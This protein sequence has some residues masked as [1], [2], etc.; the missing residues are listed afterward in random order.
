M[1]T[2]CSPARLWW[3]TI[4]PTAIPSAALRDVPPG[5]YY[6]QAVLHRYETFHRSDGHTVKLPM[7]RGEG[8]HWNI[9]PGNLYSTPQKITLEPSA[10]PIAIVLDQEI[11]PIPPPQDTKYIRHIKIQSALL[12]KFWGRPMY[13]SANVLVPEGFDAHTNVHFPLII[14]EDH[15]NADFTG[16]RTEPPDPNLKP[17]YSERFHI[18]GYNR[19]QQEE[20]YKFYQQWIAPGF[21]RVLIAD[22]NHANPYYDDSYAVNSA[23][24]GPLWRCHRDRTHSRDR[25]AIS[26]HRTRLGALRL[27][28]FHGRLGI[29]GG[30]GVLSR[31]LQR[32]VRRLPRSG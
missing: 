26:R 16:F 12:T 27:R 6:V 11:P 10:G 29:A 20:A 5:E 21:P 22:I 17:D 25:E 15:F 2:A 13:L 28:R 9:A 18:S 1:L 7:D 14:S 19:I 32:R 4:P 3:W 31:P 30:A 24:L 8:Q 23:N